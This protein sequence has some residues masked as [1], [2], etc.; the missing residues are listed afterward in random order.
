[1]NLSFG[2]ALNLNIIAKGFL[3][4]PYDY[5]YP[6]IK[7]QLF[8]RT[9]GNCGQYHVSQESAKRHTHTQKIQ[10]SEKSEKACLIRPFRTAAF[11]VNELMCVVKIVEDIE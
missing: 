10:H 8:A 1:M 9:C 11:W 6:S 3:K 4:M 2:L 7:S 5:F